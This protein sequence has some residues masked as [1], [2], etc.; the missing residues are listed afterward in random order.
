MF[1][2]I[3]TGE[4]YLRN[5]LLCNKCFA[6]GAFLCSDSPVHWVRDV[7]PDGRELSQ[8]SPPHHHP[9]GIKADAQTKPAFWSALLASLAI[10]LAKS[11]SDAVTFFD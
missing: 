4:K 2:L 6:E 7:V 1:F 10:K 9:Q 11:K 5:V 3:A 8:H